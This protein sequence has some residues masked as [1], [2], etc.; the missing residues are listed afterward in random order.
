[1][2]LRNAV[3]V[4]GVRTAFCRGGRGK[5]EAARLDDLGA[6]LIKALLERNPKVKPTMIE[7]LGIG[8]NL[9]SALGDYFGNSEEDKYLK[10]RREREGALYGQLQ[11]QMKQPGISNNEVNA[12]GPRL[13]ASLAPGLNRLSSS[14]SG[15]LG[16]DSGAA[17]GEIGRQGYGQMQGM[18]GNWQQ[19][20]MMFNAKR[21]MELMRMMTQL[22]GVSG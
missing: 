9:M 22:G 10:Q 18:M 13:Q 11:G 16:L 4:D 2:R 8:G 6:Y 3:V 15:S 21:K 19:Q 20:A 12:L 5:L 7:D 14:L 1:M 17:R